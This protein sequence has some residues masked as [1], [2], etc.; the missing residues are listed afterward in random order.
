MEK[1]TMGPFSAFIGTLSFMAFGMIA[2]MDLRNPLNKVNIVFGL[3]VGLLFGFV[4]KLLFTKLLS[5]L[6]GDIKNNHGRIAIKAT[7]KS[8][9]IF[10]FPYALLSFLAAYFL[11]WATAAVFFSAAIMNTGVTA[12]T[13]I[14]KLKGKPAIKNS[15]ATSLA[16]SAVSY[17]W[18]YSAGYLKTTLNLVDSIAKLI[19][20]LVGVKI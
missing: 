16:A 11:G 8:S 9:T 10:M 19:L 2:F 1:D 12:S 20:S 6:N 14:A 15:I 5:V 17:L 7:V 3:V 18:M 4:S 13:E